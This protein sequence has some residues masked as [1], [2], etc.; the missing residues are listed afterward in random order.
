M[1]WITATATKY[2]LQTFGTYTPLFVAA[3]CTYFVAVAVI[4]IMTPHF[5]RVEDL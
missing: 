5:R 4:Q 3:S 1:I 2:V